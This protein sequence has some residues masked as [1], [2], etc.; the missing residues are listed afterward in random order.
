MTTEQAA[1][2]F[3]KEAERLRAA[4]HHVAAHEWQTR[5]NEMRR[6]AGLATALGK[7]RR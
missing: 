3:E 5:A 2:R 1:K 7:F 4:G 6:L